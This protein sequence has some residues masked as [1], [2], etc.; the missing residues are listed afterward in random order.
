MKYISFMKS[1]NERILEYRYQL[2]NKKPS[3]SLK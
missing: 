2:L 3:L 1:L